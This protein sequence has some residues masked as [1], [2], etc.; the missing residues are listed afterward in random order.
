MSK[1]H[2]T[3]S[4]PFAIVAAAFLFAGVHPARG[5]ET[6]PPPPPSQDSVVQE[7]V[8]QKSSV[9]DSGAAESA[10]PASQSAEPATAPT[11][12]KRPWPVL[13]HSQEPASPAALQEPSEKPPQESSQDSLTAPA[14]PSLPTTSAPPATP[15]LQAAPNIPPGK[16]KNAE[17]NAEKSADCDRATFRVL[18]DVG[19]TAEHP[20]A[21]SARGVTEYSFNMRL[22]DEI[23]QKLV[24]AGFGKTV[25]LITATAPWRGLVERAEHAN[26]MLADLFVAIHHDSVPDYLLE[27][28]DYEGQQRGFSDRFKGY[29]IFISHQNADPKGSLEFGHFLGEQLKARSL[30]YTPHYTFPLMRSRR[31]ELL[32]ADAGVYRYDQLVVLEKTRM[33]A[34]LFEAGSIIN[35]DEELELAGA[36]RRGH[37]SDAV[38]AAVEDFCAA[39]WHERHDRHIARLPAPPVRPLARIGHAN[40]A[41]AR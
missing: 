30:H 4:M 23:R 36:D 39:R 6:T 19:H 33:P 31:H 40:P 2:H 41:T 21:D 7:S 12:A 3:A 25:E 26:R 18:V 5:E 9:Q 14:P 17:K 32:D 24:D 35:R 38:V 8:V 37:T 22:A 28:W 16:A 15:A 11:P 27:N 34:V 13:L 20:G 1:L 10:T 29:A